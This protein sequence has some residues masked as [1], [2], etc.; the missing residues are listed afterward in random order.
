MK[1]FFVMRAFKTFAFLAPI[2]LFGCKTPPPNY[3]YTPTGNDASI[4]FE[5]DFALHTKFKVNTSRPEQNLCS[6]FV[7]SGYILKKDSV[8]IYDTPNLAINI[9]APASAPIAVSASHEYTDG[10]FYSSCGPLS[11]T[12]TP[13]KDG[14]YVVK[15]NNIK[16]RCFLSAFE[17][18]SDKTRKPIQSNPLPKCK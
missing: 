14:L 16:D 2:L 17:I 8:F 5:S 1:T 18:D 6:D 13:K 12:F 4:S 10:T 15:M 7:T 11:L 3:K 9:S